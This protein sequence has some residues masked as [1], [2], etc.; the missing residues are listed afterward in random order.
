[1]VGL[2]EFED[3]LL[4][5][6]AC[7]NNSNNNL[8]EELNKQGP[9]K[10]VSTNTNNINKLAAKKTKKEKSKSDNLI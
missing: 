1:V 6:I 7:Y 10:R 4:L 9:I 2:P 5:D 8:R 3:K